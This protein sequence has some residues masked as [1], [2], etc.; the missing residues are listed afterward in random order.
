MLFIDEFDTRDPLVSDP[1]KYKVVFETA[2]MRI[3]YY[4]DKPG[5]KTNS[6]KHPK[7]YLYALSPFKRTIHTSSGKHIEREFKAGDTIWAEAQTHIGEN[8]GNTDTE[9]ILIE[10]KEP[11]TS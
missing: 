10:F 5:D 4:H 6:H 9:A 3:L 11:A 8:T 2:A 1:G 7:F